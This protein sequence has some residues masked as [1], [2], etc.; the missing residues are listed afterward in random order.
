VVLAYRPVSFTIGCVI[1][2]A[3]GVLL[4][5]LALRQPRASRPGGRPGIV[6]ASA[7]R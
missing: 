5:V 4:L 2:A 1:S 3:A 6:A 7:I